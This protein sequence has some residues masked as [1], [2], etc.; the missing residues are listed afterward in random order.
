M[1]VPHWRMV[2]AALRRMVLTAYGSWRRVVRGRELEIITARAA[3]L[4]KAQE[5]A[6]AAVRE[7]QTQRD[8]AKQETQDRLF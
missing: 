7:K 4:R 8:L 1:C 5:M 3:E 2:P 6:I